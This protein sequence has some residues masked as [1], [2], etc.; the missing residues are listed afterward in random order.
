MYQK[1]MNQFYQD[2]WLQSTKMFANTMIAT[3]SDAIMGYKPFTHQNERNNNNN[4]LYNKT[5]IV[6]KIIMITIIIMTE[7]VQYA[8]V[9]VNYL[10][11]ILLPLISNLIERNL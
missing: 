9:C 7:T 10:Q 8:N 4:Q 3:L 6:Q 1:L 5:N 2:A 11:L